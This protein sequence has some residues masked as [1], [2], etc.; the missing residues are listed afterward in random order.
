[1]AHIKITTPDDGRMHDAAMSRLVLDGMDISRH[2]CGFSIVGD[3][4][5]GPI[6]AHID[7]YVTRLELDVAANLTISTTPVEMAAS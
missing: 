3:P 5:K 2:V 1:M 7:L 4:D 6:Q